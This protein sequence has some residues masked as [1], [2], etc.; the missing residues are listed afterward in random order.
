ML[1]RRPLRLLWDASPPG[2]VVLSSFRSRDPEED[3]GEPRGRGVG[4]GGGQQEDEDEEEEED[5]VSLAAGTA[6]W[7]RMRAGHCPSSLSLGRESRPLARSCFGGSPGGAQA[8]PRAPQTH[9]NPVT[10][11][12]KH[13]ARAPAP[14]VFF[15][16]QGGVCFP[17]NG[18]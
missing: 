17:G 7:R 3:G 6:G 13:S 8:R 14:W 10:V 1:P 11:P 5:E 4:P 12:P 18:F 15:V 2:A 9:P 16:W